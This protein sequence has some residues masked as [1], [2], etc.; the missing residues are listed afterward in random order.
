MKHDRRRESATGARSRSLSG[1]GAGREGRR[2]IPPSGPGPIPSSARRWPRAR[3]MTSLIHQHRDGAVQRLD[4]RLLVA[5]EHDRLLRRVEVD[6]DH[7]ADLLH[8]QRSV[9]SFQ[10]S[11]RCGLSPNARHIRDTVDCDNPLALA[12]DRLDQ[13][14]SPF[15]GVSS[16]V[17]VMTSWTWASVTVRGRPGRGSSTSPSNRSAA[18]RFRHFATVGSDTPTPAAHAST[19]LDRCVSACDVFGRRT[20][21]S[22]TRR[23]SSDSS[24]GTTH[25][26]GIPPAYDL[27]KK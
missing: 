19:V 16:N 15:G 8:E 24:I 27:Q 11:T 3:H 2:A 9:D 5:A 1:G 26:P 22:S 18:N 12:I 4:L 17:L 10:V 14:M 13:W 6:A 23:S 20:Q 21:L 25:G 7:V